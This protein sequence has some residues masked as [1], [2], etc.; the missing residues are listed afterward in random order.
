M[1]NQPRPPRMFRTREPPPEQGTKTERTV[2]ES[3]ARTDVIT[4]YLSNLHNDIHASTIRCII[5]RLTIY[6]IV[7]V[8]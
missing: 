6:E 8:C 2:I 5:V 1:E 3:Y 4:L 7:C